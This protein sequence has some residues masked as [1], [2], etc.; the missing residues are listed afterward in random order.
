R[1]R[2]RSFAR[3]VSTRWLLLYDP[4][5]GVAEHFHPR[6]IFAEAARSPG[7]LDAAEAALGVAHDDGEAA[8]GGREAWAALRVGGRVV[9]Y[10]APIWQTVAAP[11]S[12]ASLRATNSSKSARTRGLYRMVAAQ[13]RPAP[14]TSP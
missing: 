13:P 12:K 11:G 1:A 5:A 10:A 4:A 3:E 6:R 14:S 2:R 8:G 7:V 9:G